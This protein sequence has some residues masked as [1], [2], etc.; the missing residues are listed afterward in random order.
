MKKEF[1]N[2]VLETHRILEEG[3]EYVGSANQDIT[4]KSSYQQFHGY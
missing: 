4:Q 2:R 3:E 1:I